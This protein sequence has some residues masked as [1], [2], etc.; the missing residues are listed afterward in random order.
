MKGLL[1]RGASGFVVH[2]VRIQGRKRLP[3]L[4]M[5]FWDR[6][7]AALGQIWSWTVGK[8]IL[9]AFTAELFSSYTNCSL[10]TQMWPGFCPSFP[11]VHVPL[12]SPA[13]VLLPVDLAPTIGLWVRASDLHYSA[14][15][16]SVADEAGG[17]AEF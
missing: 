16:P 8:D 10:S 5:L 1:P 17:W 11:S 9:T 3:L 13:L 4:G 12:F 7:A 15:S 14:S 6:L 2:L